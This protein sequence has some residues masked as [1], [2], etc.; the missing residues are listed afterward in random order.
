M[1]SLRHVASVVWT[2]LAFM[3]AA[4]L[5][6][7]L[8]YKTV[9]EGQYFDTWTGQI[10]PAER[11]EAPA[12]S[13]EVVLGISGLEPGISFRAERLRREKLGSDCARV[14]FAFPAPEPSRRY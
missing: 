6:L 13:S 12:A 5:V 3:V 11:V 7:N 10:R 14:R 4:A 9:G 8:R 2:F 1:L